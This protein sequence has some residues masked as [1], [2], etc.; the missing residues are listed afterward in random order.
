M[1]FLLEEEHLYNSNYGVTENLRV[2]EIIQKEIFAISN[3]TEIEAPE[4]V[5]ATCTTDITREANT[6]LEEE[7]VPLEPI[8]TY[9][10]KFD[11][12]FYNKAEW[13][14]AEF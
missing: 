12:K 6:F 4:L 11:K 8:I 7:Y 2:D 9:K 5:C 3:P 13:R 10:Y 1:L 14:K